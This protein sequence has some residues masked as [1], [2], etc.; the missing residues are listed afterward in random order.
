MAHVGYLYHGN[1]QTI[2]IMDIFAGQPVLKLYQHTTMQMAPYHSWLIETGN[3]RHV[4]IKVQAHY[5]LISENIYLIIMS[6]RLLHEFSETGFGK[7]IPT[8][9]TSCF[10]SSNYRECLCV[11]QKVNRIMSQGV[12]WKTGWHFES[13]FSVFDPMLNLIIKMQLKRL[14][15]FSLSLRSM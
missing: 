10:S 9:C 4:E 2:Q 6:K 7:A 14:Y 13:V 11:P 3:D 15:S 1:C 8:I 5:S 12:L